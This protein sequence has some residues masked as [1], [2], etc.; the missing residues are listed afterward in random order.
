MERTGNVVSTMELVAVLDGG[1]LNLALG[2]ARV[3]VAR[4]LAVIAREKIVLQNLSSIASP[5]QLNASEMHG[6]THGK[7]VAI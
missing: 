5:Q 1:L 3:A 6:R 7:I 4:P 2:D